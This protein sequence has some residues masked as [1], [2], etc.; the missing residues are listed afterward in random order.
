[1][2]LSATTIDVGGWWSG[3]VV[4]TTNVASLEFRAPSFSFVLHRRTFG[5]F[6]FRTHV[7]VIPSV[8]RRP[9]I[10]ELVARTASGAS[11]SKEFALA[12]V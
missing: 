8:Y 11:V 12:F 1:V 5:E 3:E 2:H 6:G 4:T 10:G 9:F 7:L